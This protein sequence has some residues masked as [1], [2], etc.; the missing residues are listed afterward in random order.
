MV[1]RKMGNSVTPTVEL[2]QNGD[3]FT[4][5]TTSTFKSTQIKFKLGVEFEEETADGRMVKTVMTM[6]GNKLVQEQ[7][8]GGEKASTIIREFTATDMTATMTIG[9]VK[10]TRWYKVE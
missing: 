5:N 10:C 2:V 7:N 9:N 1:M 6:D 4:L 3:E 8:K